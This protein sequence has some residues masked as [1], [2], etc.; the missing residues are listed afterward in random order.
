MSNKSLREFYEG[1]IN[2]MYGFLLVFGFDYF[3]KTNDKS[4]NAVVLVLLATAYITV[5][6]FW[7]VFIAASDDTFALIESKKHKS[8]SSMMLLF[9]T[10]IS[11]VSLIL[12]PL[13]LLFRN[14][15]SVKL[16]TGA[17]VNSG[18]RDPL[19]P[20]NVTP[21]FRVHKLTF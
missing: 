13:L 15:D 5:L 2:A 17:I 11:F 19:I 21:L 7:L 1:F 6:H 16:F 10:E 9:W 8:D 14:L 12:I 18:E 20:V 4:S 3:I